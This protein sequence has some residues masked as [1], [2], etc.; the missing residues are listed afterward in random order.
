MGFQPRIFEVIPVN[1][2]VAVVMDQPE[3][4]EVVRAPVVFGPHVVHVHVLAVV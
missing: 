3:I 4:R 2:P 1:L